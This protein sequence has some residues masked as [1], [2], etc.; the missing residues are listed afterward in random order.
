MAD[1]KGFPGQGDIRPNTN[2]CNM[3]DFN[4]YPGQGG[5][6]SNT[7]SEQAIF[8]RL[9]S[10]WRETFLYPWFEYPSRFQRLPCKYR[11]TTWIWGMF[12]CRWYLLKCIISVSYVL[13][14]WRYVHL[15]SVPVQTSHFIELSV[16]SGRVLRPSTGSL[17]KVPFCRSDTTQRRAFAVTGPSS[18]NSIPLQ[19]R[20]LSNDRGRALAFKKQLKS[21]LF[22][23]I[24]SAQTGTLSWTVFKCVAEINLCRDAILNFNYIYTY[25]HYVLR[26]LR[27][28]HLY[29][30]P[31]EIPHFSD[32]GIMNLRDFHLSTAPVQM[33]HFIG[34]F[35][36][37][38]KGCSSTLRTFWNTPFQ[39][40]VY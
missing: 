2:S 29:L 32:L 35:I 21:F 9:Q 30:V 39:W 26:I 1:F 3:A 31:F 7:N 27:D 15:S 18:W 28:V 5:N 38:F 23:R 6:R 14:N 24:S 36:S 11:E 20:F 40:V 10:T 25:I 33:P 22:P 8:Q 37:E 12:I 17:L 13:M 34:L 16:G 4:G 19:L